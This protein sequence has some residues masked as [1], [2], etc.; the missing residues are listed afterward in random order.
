MIKDLLTLND[1]VELMNSKDYRDRFVA[2]YVQTALR[3]EK[4]RAFNTRIE[5]EEDYD[6]GEVEHDCPLELLKE[7]Q[8]A[9]GELLHILEIRAVIEDID[10]ADAIACL[11]RKKLNAQGT[12]TAASAIAAF[13][14][15]MGKP[16]RMAENDTEPEKTKIL[17]DLTYA[18]VLDAL[19]RCA[20]QKAGVCLECPV[21]SC[22]KDECGCHEYLAG[23]ARRFLK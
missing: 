21:P 20:S 6:H 17:P 7:Q 4:L 5:T 16:Y 14:E 11:V 8:R 13:Q 1:T 19:K 23:Q 9:M 12:V 2:E 18:E 10:L 15:L 3:Y 22:L